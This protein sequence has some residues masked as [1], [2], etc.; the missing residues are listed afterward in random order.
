MSASTRGAA[1]LMARPWKGCCRR[2][3]GTHGENGSWER[4]AVHRIPTTGQ[5]FRDLLL[6]LQQSGHAP[7]QVRVGCEP[8]GLWCAKT[9]VAWSERHDYEVQWLQTWALHEHR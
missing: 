8:T 9:V 1:V 5:G 4:V 6:W 2:R 7:S 3:F